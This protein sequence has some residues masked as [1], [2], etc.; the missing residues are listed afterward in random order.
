MKFAYIP[1]IHIC[2]RSPISVSIE[3]ARQILQKTF[4]FESF[5]LLQE[6]VIQNVLDKKDQLVLMPTGGGKSLCY[7]IPA[8]LLPGTT[9][10]ISP[11]IALM[12]DQVANLTNNGIQAAFYNSSLDANESR[13]TLRKLY[14]DELDLLYISPERL[15]T[16]SFLAR[17]DELDINLFA[18]DEA[19]CVSQW[20]HDFRKDYADLGRL[21][22]MYPYVPILALTATADIDTRND[23]INRLSIENNTYISSFLRENLRYQVLNK[24]KPMQQI[25]RFIEQHKNE[26]GIIYCSTR[27]GVDKVNLQL[28]ALG[29]ESMPYHAGLTFEERSSAFHAF[30]HDEINI[31]VA[32]IAFGMG[33]DKSNIRFVIHYN[34]PK[35][36]ENFYQETGRAGRDGLT[37][38]LLLLYQYSDSMMP[39]SFIEQLTNEK[40]RHIEQGKLYAMIHFAEGNSCRQQ[41]MLNYFNETDNTPCGQCDNCLTPLE[42][43]D[44][45][46]EAQKILSCI[47]RLNQNYGMQHVIDVLRGANKKKLLEKEHDKLS[48]YGLCK[49]K[50]EEEL[51]HT[52]QQLIQSGYARQALSE[53]NVL[54]L[55]EKARSLLKG[56]CDFKATPLRKQLHQSKASG[57]KVKSA[58]VTDSGLLSLLKSVRTQLAKKQDVPPF[59][60]FS[61]ASLVDMS[62]KQPV[63]DIEFLEVH[64]VGQFKVKKYGEIFLKTIASYQED[65]ND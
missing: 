14:N 48:T 21:K 40:Q 65:Q 8:L 27:K 50:K 30:K 15:L 4:G 45:T 6:T 7:Q 60:I 12:E 42:T 44:K 23:I 47:Y 18:I 49:D 1:I 51:K 35:S 17:I 5:R 9:I 24:H 10:V 33:V 46:V 38:D 28:Q 3:H 31:I 20:G 58:E 63:D 26:P 13:R 39:F 64:G 57:R 59:M 37:A 55:T 52:I 19:H 36:I 25:Q 56:E 62:N 53:F 61:D 32:T 2:Q 11:L 34:L 41:I 29:Y 16:P 43:I 54:K 22:Q